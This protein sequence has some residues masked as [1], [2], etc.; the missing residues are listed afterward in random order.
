MNWLARAKRFLARHTA[1]IE[2]CHDCGVEQ[3]VVWTAPDRLWKLVMGGPSGVVCPAC[4][5]SRC[6]A[7][8]V[9]LRWRPDVEWYADP[10]TEQ[11][12]ERWLAPPL[13]ETGAQ[14]ERQWADAYLIAAA[15]DLLEACKALCEQFRVYR[16]GWIGDGMWRDRIGLPWDIE[17]AEAAIAKAEASLEPPR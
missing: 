5:D 17:K 9:S 2:F 12:F 15:P 1:L 4:F 10:A 11:A 7:L 3:P 13:P 8:G 6:R 16:N 14:P